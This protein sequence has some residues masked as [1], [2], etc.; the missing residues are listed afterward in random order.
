MRTTV[1][2][3]ILAQ[4]YTHTHSHT[5]IHIS[6]L[7]IQPNMM[8]CLKN[9]EHAVII[10]D[11]IRTKLREDVDSGSAQNLEIIQKRMSFLADRL[12][13]YDHQDE[14][15]MIGSVT[16]DKAQSTYVAVL[17]CRTVPFKQNLPCSD[18]NKYFGLARDYSL[19]GDSHLRW[20]ALEESNQQQEENAYSATHLGVSNL[21]IH[22]PRSSMWYER[23]LNGPKRGVWSKY[24]DDI[25]ESVMVTYSKTFHATGNSIVPGPSG[26]GVVF[27]SINTEIACPGVL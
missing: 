9:S 21:G 22:D 20:Y 10:V 14:V 11:Q 18:G 25:Y 2:I 5:H 13:S 27:A 15:N 1:Y 12:V 16:L 23:A 17:N 7:P 8:K 19:F 3:Y 26:G 6:E 4:F 24:V